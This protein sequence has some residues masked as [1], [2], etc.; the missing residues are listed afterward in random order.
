MKSVEIS[1][2]AKVNLWLEIKG[3]RPDGFHELETLMVPVSVYDRIRITAQDGFRFRCEAPGVPTD[4]SNL[5]VRA[6]RVFCEAL[7]VAPHV[8]VELWKGIPHGAGL[9]GGSSDA[10]AVLVG[11]NRLFKT[12]CSLETLSELGGRLGSDVP[13]FVWDSAAICRGRGE[14]VEPVEFRGGLPLL[15]VKP[16]FGVPTPWAYGRWAQSRELPGGNYRVQQFAWGRLVN[17]L[18]RP[19]FEKYLFLATLK[20]WLLEQ[21]GVAGALMSGSGSTMFAVLE[22]PGDT[23]SVARLRE[24]LHGE[25]GTN[26]WVEACTTL[27]GPVGALNG[28]GASGAR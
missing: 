10:A 8:C 1:A 28:P 20:N 15:L 4:E 22:A 3:K 21:P 16:P 14:R 19:V 2:A 5:A 7:G 23:E 18:E 24:G 9:G 11:L 12:G 6:V 17:D 13:F 27:S 25:F 26:L